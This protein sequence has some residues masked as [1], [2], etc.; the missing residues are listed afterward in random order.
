ME[1]VRNCWYV[2]GWD[3]EFRAEG[4]LSRKLLGEPIV[5]YRGQRGQVVALEDRCCHRAAPLSLGRREGDCLRCMYHGLK[6][7]AAGACVEAPGCERIPP[8]LGVRSYPVVEKDRFVW[9]WMGDP[10]LADASEILDFP[11]HDSAEWRMKPGYLHYKANYLLI[12]DNLLD[13]SHLAF[14]HPTTLGTASN[15]EARP[16]IERDARSLKIHWW[17]LNDQIS[18]NHR[19]VATFDG[20]VDRWQLYEWNAP[21]FMRMDS[22]SAPAGSGAPQGNRV[23]QALQF[24]HTSVQTPETDSTTHYWFCQAHNFR[25]DEQG[26]TERIY[27]DVVKAFDEDREMIEAQQRTLDATPGQPMLPI[28]ADAALNQAR[29]MIDQRLKSERERGHARAA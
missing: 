9:I 15:A 3:H 14:V 17:F 13:F 23:E 25:L 2:A 8:K 27:A 24:R 22:G 16:R 29:W 4:L 12:V 20:P 1:F 21:S 10:A 6:F 28:P 26:L 5:F 19:R 11:W 7:D 18:P